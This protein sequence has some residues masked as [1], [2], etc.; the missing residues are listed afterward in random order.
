MTS[1]NLVS[2]SEARQ[3]LYKIISLFP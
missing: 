1:N 2:I 3:I